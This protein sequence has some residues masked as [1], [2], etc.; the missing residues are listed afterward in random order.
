MNTY[1]EVLWPDCMVMYFY[2][3]FLVYAN[4]LNTSWIQLIFKF[5]GNVKTDWLSEWRGGIVTTSIP[6]K[7]D[8]KLEQ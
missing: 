6:D 3:L 4:K 1:K 5:P 2:E 7:A 8:V